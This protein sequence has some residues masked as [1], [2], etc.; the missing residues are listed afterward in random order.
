LYLVVRVVVPLRGGRQQDYAKWGGVDMTETI[1]VLVRHASLLEWAVG[2][3]KP[4]PTAIVFTEITADALRDLAAEVRALREQLAELE[5]DATLGR[6]VRTMPVGAGLAHCDWTWAG[7]GKG[8]W[9][10]DW[11]IGED[12]GATVHNR[13]FG[14]SAKAAIEAARK[15]EPT[16]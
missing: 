7:S 9:V 11:P 1:D 14:D 10:A 6:M 12:W 5:L 4:N 16:P 2:Q 13:Q 15:E 3:P 8:E